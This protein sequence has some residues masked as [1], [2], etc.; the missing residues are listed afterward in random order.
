MDADTRLKLSGHD[1]TGGPLACAGAARNSP[2]TTVPT[3]INVRSNAIAAPPHERSLPPRD[4]SLT[5][6][7]DTCHCLRS[8]ASC[9]ASAVSHRTPAVTVDT[10]TLALD[11]TTDS[12]PAPTPD[13]EVVPGYA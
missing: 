13:Q 10:Q 2:P 7:R 4:G 9:P 11:S 3:A 12:S 1:P 6:S 5:T 8:V